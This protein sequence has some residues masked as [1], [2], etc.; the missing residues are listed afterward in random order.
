MKYYDKDLVLGFDTYY[1]FMYNFTDLDY[2]IKSKYI[3]QVIFGNLNPKKQIK[4]EQYLTYQMLQYLLKENIIKHED[5][6]MISPD[7]IVCEFNNFDELFLYKNGWIESQIKSNLDL[8]VD[9]EIYK[10][11]QIK[12]FKFFVKEFINKP[13]YELMCVPIVYHAQV[14]KIYNNFEINDYDKVFFYENQVAQFIKPLTEIKD[15]ELN[16][17]GMENDENE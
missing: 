17:V 5:I 15:H 14:Y 3:R 1:D 7:E 4:I 12:P 8:N 2:M 6:R 11:E 16:K 13:G 10:L 9:V